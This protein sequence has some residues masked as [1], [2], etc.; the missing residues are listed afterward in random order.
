MNLTPHHKGV[1]QK[2]SRPI[3]AKLHTEAMPVGMC[4]LSPQTQEKKQAV[5]FLCA[6]KKLR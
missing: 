4:Y 5:M 2:E 1:M 3:F 6:V